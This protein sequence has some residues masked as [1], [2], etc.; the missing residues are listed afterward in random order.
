MSSRSHS[1]P[2]IVVKKTRAPAQPRNEAPK[3]RVRRKSPLSDE[4]L[5]GNDATVGAAA[6]PKSG[7]VAPPT[8]QTS[9]SQSSDIDNLTAGMKKIKLSLTTKAQREAREKAKLASQPAPTNTE[10]TNT[11]RTEPVKPLPIESLSSSVTIEAP[12]SQP[13]QASDNSQPAKPEPLAESIAPTPSTPQTSPPTP[14][15]AHAQEAPQVPLPASSPP[16]A[17]SGQPTLAPP[18]SSSGPDVFIA[19]QPEGPTQNTTVQ[20]EPLQWL[21]PNT[22]TP[23]PMKKADLPVF[24]STS[25][26][27][28]GANPNLG[29]APKTSS[30]DSKSAQASK[31]NDDDSVWEVPETPP[32]NK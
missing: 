5:P 25:T 13:D 22:G 30:V 24:T 18:P 9:N 20:Q 17:P 1:I 26:I 10:T 8:S 3:P 6:P 32:R 19:Y 12:V 15:P 23:A 14:L 16:E 21:P 27:P 28:F 4:R 7:S 29:Q 2:P 11:T 31:A